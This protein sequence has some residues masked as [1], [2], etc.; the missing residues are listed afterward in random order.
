LLLEPV[1]DIGMPDWLEISLGIDLATC[2]GLGLGLFLFGG[3]GTDCGL[4]AVNFV[5]TAGPEL[6]SWL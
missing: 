3:G 1:A 2:S 5:A 6:F 4:L